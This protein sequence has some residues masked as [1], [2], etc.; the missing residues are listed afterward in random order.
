MAYLDENQAFH[1]RQPP[2]YIGSLVIAL[3]GWNIRR[4]N[5]A[6]I[7]ALL[8]KPDH[9]LLDMGIERED[10][11]IALA[12]VGDASDNLNEILERK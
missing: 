9:V 7:K 6:S 12:M 10:I 2:L 11:L 8:S 3:K 5:R 1:N 4:K